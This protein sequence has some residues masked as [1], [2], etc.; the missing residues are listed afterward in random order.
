MPVK[1]KAAKRRKDPAAEAAA[2]SDVFDAEFDFFGDLAASGVETDE[3]GRPSREAI[4]D[5][6]FRLGA[7]H[8]EGRDPDAHEPWAL[9]EFGWP[10]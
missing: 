4:Q 5:A 1:R 8:I 2:W 10:A 9:R 3:H 6:W 7:I